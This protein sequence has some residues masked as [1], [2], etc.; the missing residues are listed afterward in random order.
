MNHATAEHMGTGKLTQIVNSGAWAWAELLD[1][2][3]ST[4][5]RQAISVYGAFLFIY[6]I[7]RTYSLVALIVI[8]VLVPVLIRF[9]R[10]T[11][12]Y[13]TEIKELEIGKQ[14]LKTKFFMNK[15]EILQNNK[16]NSEREHYQQL[17]GQ[18]I[19]VAQKV[20]IWEFLAFNIPSL[21]T[22][23][24]KT[25]LLL[26]AGYTIRNNTSTL[27]E[28]VG[29]WTATGYVSQ[30]ISN[31]TEGFERLPS[32]FVDLHKLRDTIDKTPPIVGYDTGKDFMFRQGNIS[33]QHIA[34]QYDKGNSVFTDFNLTIQGGTK[35]ALVGSSGSGKTTLVKLITGY[36]H[37]TGG[38]VSVDG[39]ELP[40][41][42]GS[43]N[44]INLKS[45]YQHIGYLTQEPSVFDGSIM[46]NLLYGMPDN[47]P[48]QKIEEQINTVIEL[49]Q[50][51]FISTFPDQ[52]DTQIGEK[53]VKLSGGQKQ[54]L[55]IAKLMLKNPQIIILDEP[56]SALDSFAEEEVTKALNNLFQGKTVVIIAHRLQTVKK[57]DR[58]VVIEDGQIKEDGNHE[59]LVASGGIYAK[60][61]ELQSGF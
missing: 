49:A 41:K 45:Y 15:F 7:N 14:K 38:I 1:F 2:F 16:I 4:I 40:N 53:G 43:N 9:S 3:A 35:T 25:V 54:R 30:A 32:K 52:L 8:I 19:K 44:H 21:T 26:I 61:L 22:E 33:L 59:I 46:E 24:F 12:K 39:Q 42:D 37:P 28:F 20:R 50:C 11:K 13:R 56:T 36:L 29:L 58:I 60:M 6:Q 5:F 31:I 27:P 18:T 51:Q 47:Q 34:F 10:Q 23:T 57:A 55:A 17:V 48:K